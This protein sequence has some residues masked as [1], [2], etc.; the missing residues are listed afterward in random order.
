MPYSG[1]LDML[2][3]MTAATS[4]CFSLSSTKTFVFGDST[5]GRNGT[6][7]RIVCRNVMAMSVTWRSSKTGSNAAEVSPPLPTAV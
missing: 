5:V 4:M 6:R 1:R 2:Q 3:T 7:G